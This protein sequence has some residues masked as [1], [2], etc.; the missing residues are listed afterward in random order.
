M[1]V[2]EDRVLREDAQEGKEETRE[3]EQ[4]GGKAEMG[5]VEELER[6]RRTDGKLLYLWAVL[7][8]KAALCGPCFGG[9]REEVRAVETGDSEISRAIKAI[10]I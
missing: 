6:R 2:R 10:R 7:K 8:G 5:W 3:G 9:R 1:H 4:A